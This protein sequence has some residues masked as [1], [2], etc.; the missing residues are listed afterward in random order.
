[1]LALLLAIRRPGG[2]RAALVVDDRRHGERHGGHELR[3]LVRGELPIGLSLADLR[4][5]ARDDRVD[6]T[7]AVLAGRPV[8]DLPEALACAELRRDVGLG[9]SEVVASRGRGVERRKM[10]GS[11]GSLRCSTTVRMPR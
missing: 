7:V 1:M 2:V 9:Q 11:V 5:G 8:R 10:R 4:V 6:Q 3:R